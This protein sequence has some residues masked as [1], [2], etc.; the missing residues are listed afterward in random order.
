MRSGSAPRFSARLA[1]LTLPVLAT[2][3]CSAPAGVAGVS[4]ES[5]AARPAA[6]ASASQAEAPARPAAADPVRLPPPKVSPYKYAFPV[7]GC[8]VTYARKLLVLP[9]T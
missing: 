6:L 1:L 9:K 7:A 2:A 3:A 5:A 8:H 4:T